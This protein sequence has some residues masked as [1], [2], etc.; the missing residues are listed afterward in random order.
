[1]GNY[2]IIRMNRELKNMKYRALGSAALIVLS[3][4][5]Y[6]GMAGMIPNTEKALEDKV[7]DHDL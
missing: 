3:V 6:I 1:M 4:T 2:L 7:N 5:F